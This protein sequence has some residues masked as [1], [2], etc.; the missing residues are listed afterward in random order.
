AAGAPGKAFHQGVL[1]MRR[2]LLKWA[3]AP[4]LPATAAQRVAQLDA[5]RGVA[6]CADLW[7]TYRPGPVVDQGRDI[8]VTCVRVRGMGPVYEADIMTSHATIW[9]KTARFHP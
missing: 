8:H 3:V 5:A 1:L 9:D 6:L 4:W 7:E 2:E